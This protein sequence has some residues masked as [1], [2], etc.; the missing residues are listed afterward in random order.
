MISWAW[1]RSTPCTPRGPNTPG[2]FPGVFSSRVT[3][4]N[5]LT[6]YQT[7]CITGPRKA[8]GCDH[9]HRTLVKPQR[10]QASTPR[11]RPVLN[12]HDTTAGEGWGGHARPTTRRSERGVVL[13]LAFSS[14]FCSFSCV[15]VAKLLPGSP[16]EPGPCV[17]PAAEE[18]AGP[19]TEPVGGTQQTGSRMHGHHSFFTEQP[20]LCYPKTVLMWVMNPALDRPNFQT[21]Q[22]AQTRRAQHLVHPHSRAGRGY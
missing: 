10:A 20:T 19:L 5:M 3:R 8:R 22:K 1:M 2:S 13:S 11:R 9:H 21:L 17:S 12:S 18:A 7:R 6:R 16:T 15:P 4:R 14:P